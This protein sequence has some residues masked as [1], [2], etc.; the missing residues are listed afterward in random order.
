MGVGRMCM[1]GS[2]GTGRG[3]ERWV[4]SWVEIGTGIGI[5]NW[6]ESVMEFRLGAW[7]GT[8]RVCLCIMKMGCKTSMEDGITSL[9][10]LKVKVEVVEAHYNKVNIRTGIR[11]CTNR[12]KAS[13]TIIISYTTDTQRII[14]TRLRRGILPHPLV[15]PLH[16]RR[17]TRNNRR[18]VMCLGGA[19]LMGLGM[20]VLLVV[21]LLV[22]VGFGSRKIEMGRCRWGGREGLESSRG[23]WVSIL[24]SG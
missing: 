9:V 21:V 2:S 20:L 13:R 11:R 24:F 17:M 8:G 19:C 7:R 4:E 14:I 12:Y 3:I 5:G 10:R 15:L 1:S 18:A 22:V 6:G 23:G 16:S